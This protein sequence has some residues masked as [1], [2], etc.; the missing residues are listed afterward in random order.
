[1]EM[2]EKGYVMIGYAAFNS[3]EAPDSPFHDG[4]TQAERTGTK[5][6]LKMRGYDPN[7]DMK[8]DPTHAAIWANAAVVAVQKGYA[9]SRLETKRQRIRTDQGTESTTWSGRRSERNRG[10]YAGGSSGSSS[11]SGNANS[12]GKWDEEGK[13][14]S[15]GADAEGPSAEAGANWSEGTNSDRTKYNERTNYNDR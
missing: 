8:G 10:L 7:M 12:K 13:E 3:T 4:M 1:M 2:R 6:G 9:F 15:V 5:I 14:V 11:T